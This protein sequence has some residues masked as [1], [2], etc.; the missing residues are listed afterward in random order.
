MRIKEKRQLLMESATYSEARVEYQKQMANKLVYPLLAF[1]RKTRADL[2]SES[3]QF[4]LS[5]FQKKNSRDSEVE[6]G[7][8]G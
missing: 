5:R 3:Q 6:F 1:F 4:I 8:G 7:C 2:W